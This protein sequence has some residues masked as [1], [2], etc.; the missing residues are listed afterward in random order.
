MELPVWPAART[1]ARTRASPRRRRWR[2]AGDRL[3]PVALSDGDSYQ[4]AAQVVG[5]LVD[6][7]RE[8]TGSLEELVRPRGGAVVGFLAGLGATGERAAVS[9][10]C[11]PPRARCGADELAAE[12][13]R[14]RAR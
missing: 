12:R 4:R 9:R 1:R 5:A 11:W 3:W 2:A 14:G 10:S 7:L 8:R 6:A 13:T